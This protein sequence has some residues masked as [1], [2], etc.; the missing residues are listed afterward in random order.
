MR[1][2]AELQKECDQLGVAVV[3]EGR[4]SKEPYIAAL[5]QYRWRMEHGN[6]PLPPQTTP[7][8]LADWADVDHQAEDIELDGSGW[9][10]QPKLDGVRALLHIDPE[11]IR[12]TGRTISQV[13][14]RLSEFQDNLPHLAHGLT[15]LE[16]T[17]LDGELVCPAKA[18][19]TGATVTADTLQST[20]AILATDPDSARR[21]QER[22]EAH[23]RFHAFDVLRACG[24]D[25]TELSL[26]RRND[27]LKEI[28]GEIDNEHIQIVP[29][30]VTDKAQYHHRLIEHR[31]EGTVWK[32]LDSTYQPGRR[33]KTWIKRKAEVQIEAF[34]SGFK[35]GSAGTGHAE[36]VGALEFSTGDPRDF[37]DA[38]A[39]VSALPDELRDRMT[40][41]GVDGGVRLAREFYGRKAIVAGH[42]WSAKSRRLRHARLVRWLA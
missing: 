21:I 13:T 19:H 4:P 38:V 7:M 29:S 42:D 23:V 30:F 26:R 33:V 27:F 8:L 5:R 3:E 28:L 14:Y 32:Q 37:A 24:E 31:A 2:L 16:G 22:H 15:G 25:V 34:V 6:R 1:T 11:G 9:I 10:V 35:P 41:R 17:M 40:E 39:W 12:I 20:V 18:V 36:V